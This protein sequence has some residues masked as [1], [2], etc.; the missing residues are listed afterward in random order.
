MIYY[1]H[2]TNIDLKPQFIYI[3]GN[4]SAGAPEFKVQ[5]QA[6]HPLAPCCVQPAVAQSTRQE[7]DASNK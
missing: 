5:G 1:E 6:M 4:H 2:F 7:A 3:Y